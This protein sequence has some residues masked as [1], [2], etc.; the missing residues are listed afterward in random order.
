ML[1][2]QVISHSTIYLFVITAFKMFTF[3][4]FCVFDLF[5]LL[6][7]FTKRQ[8]LFLLFLVLLFIFTL[9]T[10]FVPSL[11]TSSL[12]LDVYVYLFSKASPRC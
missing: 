3:Y 9:F 4:M 12:F 1:Y 6:F 8:Y 5:L 11:C 2:V 10:V 7:F